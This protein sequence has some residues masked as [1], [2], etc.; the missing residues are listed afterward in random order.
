[1]TCL[2]LF[3]DDWSKQKELHCQDYPKKLMFDVYPKAVTKIYIYI[4][5]YFSTIFVFKYL[6]KRF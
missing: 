5:F 1:M 6:F 3:G 2:Q 4:Y